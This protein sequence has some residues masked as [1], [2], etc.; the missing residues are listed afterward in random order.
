MPDIKTRDVIKGTIKTVDKTA[1]AGERMKDAYVRMKEKGE[2]S[3][4]SSES[5]SNEYAADHLTGGIETLTHEGIHQIEKQGQK[6]LDAT[7]ANVS[8]AKAELQKKRTANQP[9]EQHHA[10]QA[11]SPMQPA[12]S[13]ES[14]PV[15]KMESPPQSVKHQAVPRQAVPHTQAKTIKQR[16]PDRTIRQAG[17]AVDTAAKPVGASVKTASKTIKTADTTAQVS[18]KTAQAS[19]ATAQKAA[20]AAERTAQTAVQSFRAA[21]KAA[22][23]TAKAAAKAVVSAV[24]GIVE[25][26]KAL[27]SAIAAGGWVAILV[28]IVICLI[29]LIV[30]S[31][32]GIF[33]SNEDTGSSQ[34]MQEVVREINDEYLARLDEIK[35]STTYDELEMSGARA[36]WPEVLAVYAVKTTT[37]PDNPQEVASITDEKKELLKDIF[38]QMN[39][40]SHKTDMVSETEIV[41]SDD[42]NGN[43]V[44]EEVSVTNTYLYITIEHKTAEEMAEELNFND[45]QMAQ[46]KALLADKND[47]L[48]AVVLYGIGTSDDAI[49]AVA[50]SQVGNIGGQPYWSWYG[51]DSR[52]AWCACFVSWCANECGYI[53]AG[54]IPKFAGCINGVNWFRERGQWAD[55]SATPTPGMIIFFDW[56]NDEGQDGLADH[57]GIVEK[58]ENGRVYTIEGNT[59]DSCRERSY[60]LGYYEILGYGIPAY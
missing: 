25:G 49:V 32:F 48:W 37:D 33:F 58:V 50:L 18:I 8:K 45:D 19:A 54:V 39:E 60:P 11:D 34:T 16:I 13:G 4:Y 9:K 41:E 26:T 10:P 38:W 43:I 31:S 5:S 56:D 15:P 47:S 7:K 1:V 3:V 59:S 42:G 51:F 27:I 28:V 24:K 52:V 30:G 35:A 29:G 40:I 2:H 22:A 6:G 57:V 14:T 46:L 17:K 23:T 36:V 44:E 53:D 12:A 21:A 20:V 55:S